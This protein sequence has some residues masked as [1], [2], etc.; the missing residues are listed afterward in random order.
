MEIERRII[1]Y[2]DFSQQNQKINKRFQEN[3]EEYFEYQRQLRIQRPTWSV[4]PLTEI[5]A[6]VKT[7]SSKLRIGDFGCGLDA[8]LMNELGTDRVVGFDHIATADNKAIAVDMKDVSQYVDYASLEVV[9]FCLSLMGK[10]WRNYIVEAKRCLCVRGSMLI[11]QTTREL[12]NGQR[13][14]GL[15]EFISQQGFVIDLDEVRGDFTFIEAT[16]L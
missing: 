8:K 15:R 4:D 1:K 11:A 10:N 12:E 5:I 14:S 13:L 16:K 2:G 3:P 6:R 7:M 9:V